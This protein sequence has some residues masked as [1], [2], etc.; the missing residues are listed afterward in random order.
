MPPL[1]A[2]FTDPFLS[3]SFDAENVA[4][5][6]NKKAL[7]PLSYKAFSN[8]KNDSIYRLELISIKV[9]W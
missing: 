1:L 3:F 2:I 6:G 5:G 8:R 4:F 9:R 7:Q